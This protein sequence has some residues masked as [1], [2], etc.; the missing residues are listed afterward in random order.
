MMG[1]TSLMLVVGV[2]WAGLVVSPLALES[3]YL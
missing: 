3:G 2:L 1:I